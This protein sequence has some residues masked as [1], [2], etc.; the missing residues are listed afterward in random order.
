[1]TTLPFKQLWRSIALSNFTD[2]SQKVFLPFV[3]LS[4]AISPSDVAYV[5]TFLTLGWPLFGLLSGVIVD[6]LQMSSMPFWCHF[7]RSLLFVYLALV[8]HYGQIGLYHLYFAAFI[9][10]LFDV[11]FEVSLPKLVLELTTD[12]NRVRSNTRLAV[13][14]TICSEFLGPVLGSTLSLFNPVLGLSV[15]ALFYTASAG[16]LKFL[17]IGQPRTAH[18]HRPRQPILSS[19]IEPVIWLLGNRVLIMLALVGFAM[20]LSWGAWLSLEP[21]YLIEVSP[22]TL[23]KVEFGFMMAVLAGGAVC[24]ALLFERIQINKNNLPLLFVDATGII[25]LLLASSFTKNPF[26]VGTALFLT[27]IGA[28]IWSSIVITMRQELV[29]RHLLGGVNGFFR[30]IVY[31]GLPAG[32]FIGGMLADRLSIPSSYIAIAAISAVLS[33]FI[34]FAHWQRRKQA[35]EVTLFQQEACRKNGSFH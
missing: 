8:A 29:P 10:G 22:Q 26:F 35:C 17:L 27:G 7:V 11:L 14:H 1:V 9:F 13:T 20:S 32:S 3:A 2:G 16:M 30:V 24:A 28:T 33:P 18:E 5:F 21:Y 4:L 19:L 15:I 31:G 23:T 25:A 6:R 34:L 12:E